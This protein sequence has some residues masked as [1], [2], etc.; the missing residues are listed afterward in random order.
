MLN[1]VQRLGRHG[2]FSLYHVHKQQTYLPNTHTH[3]I[4]CINVHLQKIQIVSCLFR[5]IPNIGILVAVRIHQRHSIAILVRQN[6]P[7]NH[8]FH[9][10]QSAMKGKCVFFLKKKVCLTFSFEPIFF[11]LFMTLS[12]CILLFFLCFA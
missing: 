12:G 9:R 10:L 1:R 2:S 4:K 8:L 3:T 5:I 11:L 7:R 6:S